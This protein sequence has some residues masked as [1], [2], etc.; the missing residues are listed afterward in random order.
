MC[1]TIDRGDTGRVT[2]RE[3]VR[4]ERKGREGEL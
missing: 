2:D 1:R 4:E 3:T